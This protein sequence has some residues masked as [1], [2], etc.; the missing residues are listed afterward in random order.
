MRKIKPDMPPIPLCPPRDPERS[1]RAREFCRAL[2]EM[3]QAM[4]RIAQPQALYDAICRIA[5][6]RGRATMAW[7]G[8][9]VGDEVQAVAWG[10]RAQEYT[11]G[12]LIP[13]HP[14]AGSPPGPVAT[15]LASGQPCVCNDFL[16]DPRTRPWRDRA[17]RFGVQASAAFPFRRG[18]RWV[19]ALS[20]YFPYRHAFDEPLIE[21]MRDMAEDLSFALD[22]IDHEGRLAHAI[23]EVE[24]RRREL[25]EREAQLA[26]I[27]DTALDA[28]ITI[29]AG[30]RVVV[31]NEAAAKM[32]GVPRGEAMGQTLDRFLPP[33]VR[34]GH[35]AHLRR[36]AQAGPGSRRMGHAREVTAVRADGERFPMEAAISRV[37]RGERMLMTVMARDVTQL[38]VAEKAQLARTAAEA[39]NQAKTE[40][41]SRISHELRTPLNAVLGFAQLMQSDLDQPL[42][43][44]H[45]DRLERVLQAG[46]HLRV[47]ID[48]M[49]DI[50][51]I[52]SGA[53]RLV[54][55]V[56][57]VGV[58]AR[59]VLAMCSA[60]AI[61]FKVFLRRRFAPLDPLPLPGDAGRLRQILLNLVSNAI[62]Y[63]RPEGAVELGFELRGRRLVLWVED[64]GQGMTADQ[65]QH[66]FQ[67]FNRLGRESSGVE[68]TGIGLVLVRQLVGLMGGEL[69][70]ESTAGRGTRVEVVLPVLDAAEPRGEPRNGHSRPQNSASAPNELRGGVLYVEDN[71]IN[72]IL[73]EQ[74]L[75]RWP[76]VELVLADTV[77]SGIERAHALQPDLILLDM[78]LPDGDGLQALERLKG[79]PATRDLRVVAL[80][81]SAMPDQVSAARAAGAEDYWTKPIDFGRFIEGIERLLS[82]GG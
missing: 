33:E 39:A 14:P 35:D 80:S 40:F 82:D 13:L 10:G 5:V 38:R 67:P 32:F 55:G 23:Q 16:G 18:G 50:S 75:A 17:Q 24:E 25:Q 68:G 58:V 74:L 28:I 46:A 69:S 70:I 15:A 47:L 78:Q 8:V 29:D 48:E 19:G 11:E 60:Q 63:N 56:V 61:E 76:G 62:K 20:L 45:L 57:D 51:R 65:R 81:A 53:L 9:V 2:A 73:V 26:D 7:I 34:A 52:E 3:N 1:D 79:D 49:L 66:L 4:V 41:L 21:L 36:F 44:H 64:N 54:P 6:E 27:V 71:P 77:A 31:F 37:G 43:Q 59:E 30:G 72:A 42:P 22:H 12:L